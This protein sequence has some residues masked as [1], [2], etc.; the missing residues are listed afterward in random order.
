MVS[1]WYSHQATCSGVY[2]VNC[3]TPLH[4]NYLE[5]RY[6]SS[7]R[8]RGERD[9]W[10]FA[11]GMYKYAHAHNKH[12]PMR[13]ANAHASLLVSAHFASMYWR[14]SNIR[15][16]FIVKDGLPVARGAAQ[17]LNLNCALILLP[18][19]RNMVNAARGAFEGKRSLRRLFDKNILFH[20]WCT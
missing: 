16:R 2:C 11:H 7:K 15:L 8:A 14:A 19:C 5:E 6:P 10:V 1:V 9:V 18:V 12:P 20:K 3:F 17:V 4:S 13:C